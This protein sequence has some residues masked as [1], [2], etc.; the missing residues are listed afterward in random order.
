[1]TVLNITTEAYKDIRLYDSHSWEKNES[2]L[3]KLILRKID[4]QKIN[5][6][7]HQI[8][9]QISIKNVK[10]IRKSCLKNARYMQSIS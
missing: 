2:N 5:S 6:I 8:K 7:L 10:E 4:I 9:Y 3:L 1:M